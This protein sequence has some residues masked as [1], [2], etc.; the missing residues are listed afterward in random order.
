FG[1]ERRRDVVVGA[2]GLAET[3]GRIGCELLFSRFAGV[4]AFGEA[5]HM[6]G[7]DLAVPK[8]ASV[9]RRGTG[10]SEPRQQNQYRPQEGAERCF[11][12][13]G[14]ADRPAVWKHDAQS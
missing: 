1:L 13:R 7:I 4:A 11:A 9:G 5:E 2:A 14:G 3:A 12:P 8:F 10:C 6:L